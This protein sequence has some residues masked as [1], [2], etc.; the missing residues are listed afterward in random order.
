LFI[1]NEIHIY[2]GD[3]SGAG[4]VDALE[5]YRDDGRFVP[6]RD[7][8][9]LSRALPWLPQKFPSNRAFAAASITEVLGEHM[10]QARQLRVNWPDST[11]LLNR[12]DHFEVHLLPIE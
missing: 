1:H 12:G 5:A 7:L 9:T 10:M 11:L 8:Q 6:R 2:Y 4:R 3:F